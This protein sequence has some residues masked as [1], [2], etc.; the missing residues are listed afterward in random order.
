MA[1][2]LEDIKVQV[3]YPKEVYWQEEIETVMAR[4][5]LERQIEIY[6]EEILNIIYP[7]WIKM[8]E[9]KVSDIE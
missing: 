7:I 6:G 2:K 4:W 3:N 1:I 5:I 8:K 9:T